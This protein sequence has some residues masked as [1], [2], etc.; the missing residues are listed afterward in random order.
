M[1]TVKMV[2]V[3]KPEMISQE[4][5]TSNKYGLVNGD[6]SHLYDEPDT[7]LLPH[8]PNTKHRYPQRCIAIKPTVKMSKSYP[9][10]SEDYPDLRVKYEEG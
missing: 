8:H 9:D 10:K 2:N 4:G 6:D 3:S 7:N 1:K 5:L